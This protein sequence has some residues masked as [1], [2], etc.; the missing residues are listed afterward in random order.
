MS[1]RSSKTR[2]LKA[3]TSKFRRETALCLGLGL[4]ILI[5]YSNSF[6][7]ALLFDS[8]VII[9]MDPRLRSLNLDN[10]GNILTR[11]YWWPG[12]ESVLY[13]PLTTLSYLFNYS[14]L[15]NVENVV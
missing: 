4:L 8:E 11:N 12:S 3:S 6:T 13:R 1:G 2:N 7:A 9:K 10:L 14:I 15:G 5:V